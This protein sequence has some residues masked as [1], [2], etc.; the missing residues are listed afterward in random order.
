MLKIQSII[1]FALCLALP[2]IAQPERMSFQHLTLEDGLSQSTITSILQDKTGFMWFGT[3]IGLNRFDGYNFKTYVHDP[4][5]PSSLSNNSIV[6]IYED[7]RGNLWIGTE[8]G[9][10]I[11]DY[12]TGNI[13]KY[14]YENNNP[15]SLSHDDVQSIIED[16]N[17][18]IWLGMYGGGISKVIF[19]DQENPDYTKI[20]FKR[21]MH[22]PSIKYSINNNNVTAV[23]VDSK[24]RFWVGNDLG[25]SIFDP[26]K[27]MFTSFKLR[28]ELSNYRRVSIFEDSYKNIWIGTWGSG[29]FRVDAQNK[30]TNYAPGTARPVSHNVIRTIYEDHEKELWVGT[31]GGGLH[32]YNRKTDSFLNFKNDPADPNSLSNNS[33]ISIYQDRS[34][35]LWIGTDFGGINTFDKNNQPFHHFKLEVDKKLGNNSNI[36]TTIYQTLDDKNDILWLGTWEGG[37]KKVDRKNNTVTNYLNKP[38]D[39][40][41]LT[42]NL[43]RSFAVDSEGVFWLGTNAGLSSYDRKNDR[44]TAYNDVP[45]NPKS[46][47]DDNVFC[48][49]VDRDDDVWVGT[50]FGGLSRLN[51]KTGTFTH[52][53]NDPS[54]S[55]SL[56]DNGVW[57]VIQDREG[58]LWV[59]TDKGGLNQL[60]LPVAGEHNGIF[61]RFR[62]DD[63]IAGSLA[64]DKVLSIF[65][66]ADGTIWAGTTMGLSKLDKNTGRFKNYTIADGLPANPIHAMLQDDNGNLWISTN[67]GL[68]KLHIENE[69]FKNYNQNNGLQSDEF[70]VNSAFKNKEG[71]LF[72]GGTNGYNSFIP[73]DIID[74]T[75]TPV[76]AISDFQ[77]FNNSVA[78]GSEYEG[79]VILNKSINQST[80]VELSYLHNVFSFEYSALD[81]SSPR[82]N[83]YAYIMEGFE[84]EWNHVGH[85]RFAT[86]IN[87]PAGDYTFRVIGS[88]SKGIWNNEGASIKIRIVPPFWKTNWFISL[89]VLTVLF[90]TYLLYEFRIKVIKKQNIL[91]EKKVKERTSN[92]SEMNNLL[93]D[94]IDSRRKVE[95]QLLFA[96]ETAELANKSKSDFVSNMSHEIRTPLNGVIGLTELMLETRLTQEQRNYVKMVKHSA[97]QLLTIINDILDFSKIEA[98]HLE[99]ESIFFK[100]REIVEDAGDILVY[101][102]EKKN[103]VLNI[104][105][106]PDVP[107]VLRGDP[108]RLRQILVNLISNSYKFTE[109]GEITVTVTL[110]GRIKDKANLKFS[111]SDTGPGISPGRFEAIFQSFTQADTSITRKFGGTGLGLPISKQLCEMM[112]GKIWVES[113]AKID[114]PPDIRNNFRGNSIGGPGSTFLF[115]AQFHIEEHK[116]EKPAIIG[117]LK[118]L[119]IMHINN[120]PIRRFVIRQM[121]SKFGYTVEDRIN[122]EEI[123]PQEARNF[124]AV[125]IDQTSINGDLNKY[126]K[127]FR[128]EFIVPVLILTTISKEKDLNILK[129]NEKLWLITKPVKQSALFDTL[130]SILNPE[131]KRLIRKNEKDARNDYIE[132]LKELSDDVKIL[133]VEDNHINQRVALALLSKTGIRV[134]VADD[135]IMALETL[136]KAMYD[137]VLM[138]IAMPNMDGLTATEKI[139]RELGLNIPVIA[140]T[141][142]AMKGDSEKC[143]AVGMNDYISKPISPDAFYKTLVKWLMAEQKLKRVIHPN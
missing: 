79:H 86:Y 14:F 40:Q 83:R 63:K 13:L 31:N 93:L 122:A 112:G 18:N 2:L 12:E 78:V 77:I 16:K 43:I 84:S 89:S 74:N 136:K 104:Y 50:W 125:I 87:L 26:Q 80:S 56:S 138:D 105:I 133:L 116:Q 30:I 5:D 132:K 73:D 134:E 137:I 34:G 15:N 72:F 3:Y 68:S 65:E 103:L 9:L 130:M 92:L 29:L 120:H 88:N 47:G 85:R 135:G 46:L 139:R 35:I 143:F 33:V 69:T 111:V 66:D 110:E 54:D 70:N 102:I 82:H 42:N 127:T 76:I 49:F 6:C 91:L 52:F 142:Q 114:F 24:N 23:Y 45:S 129:R 41:S 96:K 108:I 39:K 94:E 95:D 38:G 131:K 10:N 44:F 48:V 99:L 53:R 57:S 90:I 124:D 64:S 37:L 32:L 36:I 106:A 27:E 140:M 58:N 123:N 21:Y 98:G 113:P 97:D 59:G 8:T 107:E 7:S 55:N 1:F 117:H 109:K 100:V 51:R 19:N 126:I 61:K 141:A 22:D 101:L 128:K 119:K 60:I 115:T 118:P 20:K 121:L 11:M 62:A 81:F 67:K 28:L 17:G 71:R 4:H 75:H 25:V